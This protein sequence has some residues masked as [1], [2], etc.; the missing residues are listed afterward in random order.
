MARYNFKIEE[1]TYCCNGDLKVFMKDLT[2]YKYSNGRK[3]DQYT[4]GLRFIPQDNKYSTF[5][6]QVDPGRSII[7]GF[8]GEYIN[9]RSAL[10]N[11]GLDK[12]LTIEREV[13]EY[14]YLIK[15]KC[16]I[17]CN[18]IVINAI[19]NLPYVFKMI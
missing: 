5:W 11:L 12:T 16:P 14:P 4:F 7:W 13:G 9:V 18:E 1:Q 6:F 3:Y 19:K 15:E 10:F 8:W 17:K 2:P